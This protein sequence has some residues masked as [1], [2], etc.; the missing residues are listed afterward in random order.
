MSTSF[1]ISEFDQTVVVVHCPLHTNISANLVIIIKL[2]FGLI[3]GNY[4][5]L[6]PGNNISI[7]TTA[8]NVPPSNG[9]VK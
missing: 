9:E 6:Y 5:L 4:K 1:G 3:S 7:T 8:D 2:I